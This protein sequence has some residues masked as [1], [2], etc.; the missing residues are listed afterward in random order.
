MNC[1]Q[2]RRT[3]DLIQQFYPLILIKLP[4][5]PLPLRNLHR[6][7]KS[8]DKRPNLR[9]LV[10][11]YHLYL[12]Y[13]ASPQF[14]AQQLLTFDAKLLLNLAYL[15]RAFCSTYLEFYQLCNAFARTS[16]QGRRLDLCF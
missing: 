11:N 16:F 1:I 7:F 6:L 12:Q 10:Q 5:F 4:S 9:R 8:H 14:L 13:P 15:F 3:L 2:A